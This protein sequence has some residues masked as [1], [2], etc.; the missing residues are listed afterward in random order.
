MIKH[1]NLNYKF[2]FNETLICHIDEWI[3][4][5]LGVYPFKDQYNY[6]THFGPD[7]RRAFD[8][9]HGYY[10]TCKQNI[11]ETFF[12]LFPHLSKNILNLLNK[13]HV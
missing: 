4:N 9:S 11:L 3:E 13:G 6:A 8:E 10:L 5:G 2:L 12:K 7:K 1:H